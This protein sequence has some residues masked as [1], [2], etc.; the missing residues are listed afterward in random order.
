[1]SK[2]KADYNWQNSGR[3]VF[4]DATSYETLTA[5]YPCQFHDDFTGG[6]I[7]IPAATSEE[8]GCKWSKLITTTLGSPTV[9]GVANIQNGIVAAAIDGG[10]DEEEGACLYM[11]DQLTFS[12][13]QGLI[14]EARVKLKILPTIDGADS[15]VAS[16]GLW[17][18]WAAAS[19]YRVGFEAIASGAVNCESDD[20][21]AD[22]SASSGI[23]VTTADWKIYR[24][25]CTTQTD[26]KFFIDGVRVASGTTFSNAAAGANALM[27]PYFGV[28]K[29]DGEAVG[30]IQVDYVSL[31]QNRS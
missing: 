25:D 11:S 22:T 3:Q 27:Q 12:I 8:S 7:V 6:D 9:A 2:T 30:T 10:Q 18:A 15:A 31:W 14:F 17:G 16:W 24:I 4:S 1:M 23:T 13:A 29:P 21:S 19:N 28:Y 20:T 5:L 26:I